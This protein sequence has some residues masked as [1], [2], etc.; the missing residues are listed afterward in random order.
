LKNAAVVA[1]LEAMFSDAVLDHFRNPRNAGELPSATVTVEVSNPVCGDILKLSARIVDGRV[2]EVRFLCR[3]CT[4]AIACASFLTE[5][6]C[7]RT[8]AE[9]RSLTP[10]SISNSLGGLPPTTFHGAQLAIDGLQALLQ[11]SA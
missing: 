3:G 7:G 6:I 4:T 5:Q 2:T 11:K 1:I 8:F 10:E 9:A